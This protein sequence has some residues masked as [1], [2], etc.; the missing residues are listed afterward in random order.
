[1]PVWGYRRGT[2]GLTSEAHKVPR[3]AFCL[4]YSAMTTL[5]I[6]RAIDSGLIS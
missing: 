6:K 1:M 2:S 4:F 3:Y 5:T